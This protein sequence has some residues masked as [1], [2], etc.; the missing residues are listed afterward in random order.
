MAGAAWLMPAW[1][2]DIEGPVQGIGFRPF[3]YRLATGLGLKGWVTNTG[4]GV[5]SDIVPMAQS[6]ERQLL[7]NFTDEEAE[8][9]SRLLKKLELQAENLNHTTD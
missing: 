6:Y 1:Q 5:Y 2:L 9:L 7:A 3:I 8:Q 4:Q